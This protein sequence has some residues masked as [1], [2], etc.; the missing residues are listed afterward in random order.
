MTFDA[1]ARHDKGVLS[2][3]SFLAAMN[4]DRTVSPEPQD[5]ENTSIVLR[6]GDEER[7]PTLKEAEEILIAGA[8]SRA[9]GN[10]GVA[11]GYLGIS[12]SALN[13]KLIRAKR[14]NV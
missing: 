1:V 8:M 2:M 12:R 11:A 4:T 7:I 5:T 14:R 13:K 9:N 6:T 10:Q 3:E